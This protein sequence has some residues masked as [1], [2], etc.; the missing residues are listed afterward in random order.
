MELRDA[1]SSRLSLSLPATV[2][3]DHPTPAALAAHVATLLAERHTAVA[4]RPHGPGVSKLSLPE[5]H[6]TISASV[7]LVGVA[8]RYPGAEASGVAVDL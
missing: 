2:V 1:L 4:V 3:F 6:R 8:C 7:Q 5:R